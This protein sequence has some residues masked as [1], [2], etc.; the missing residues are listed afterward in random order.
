MTMMRSKSCYCNLC[1]GTSYVVADLNTGK[2]TSV[3]ITPLCI[4]PA[5]CPE[6]FA[7]GIFERTFGGNILI[8]PGP[9][10]C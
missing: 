7:R 3:D 9:P 6:K 8:P 4:W 1:K 5:K 10:I 2:I